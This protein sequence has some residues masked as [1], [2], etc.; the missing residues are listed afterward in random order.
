MRYTIRDRDT[1][2]ELFSAEL[3][4]GFS[5]TGSL[6][7]VMKGINRDFEISSEALSGE[8]A[9]GLIPGWSCMYEKI[10]VPSVFGM[11]PRGAVNDAGAYYSEPTGVTYDLDLAA[12]NILG[13]RVNA[14]NYYEIGNKVIERARKELGESVQRLCTELELGSQLS[15]F[16]I[17]NLLRNYL[18]DGGLGVYPAG[19]GILAVCIYRYGT[20]ADVVQNMTGITEMLWDGPFGSAPAPAGVVT[21]S[22][23]WTVPYVF[24]MKGREESLPVFARF[25][26]TFEISGDVK[27]LSGE[28]WRSNVDSQLA[29]ARANTAMNQQMINSM[30]EQHRRGWAASDALRDSI[31]RD[32]ESFHSGLQQSM[33]QNDMRFYRESSGE[34]PDDR[35]QRWRHESMM[36]VETYQR[37]NGTD[38][39]FDSRADRVF[40]NDLDS[41]E[42]FGTKDYYDDWVPDGWHELK[43]K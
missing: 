12:A 33:A 20:E 30:W 43:K 14:S 6:K 36:G 1:G 5:V 4:E 15:P 24:Y 13:S 23:V 41:T 29:Q 34:S 17:G 2:R 11:A 25:V 40:E 3:P 21:S 39:E 35:I 32:L 9:I 18:L 42:R 8:M 28:L 22:A 31:H 16:P 37:E 10:R 7:N 19:G 26:E 38:V 27:A